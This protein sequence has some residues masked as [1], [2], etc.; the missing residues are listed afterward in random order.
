MSQSIRLTEVDEVVAAVV[1][2]TEP[3]VRI[4]IFPEGVQTVNVA[5]VE[6][7]NGIKAYVTESTS[8]SKT[9]LYGLTCELVE[10]HI[11]ISTY[12]K[13]HPVMGLL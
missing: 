1:P 6:V 5:V 8:E 11:T 10:R 4:D 9:W 2:S 13:M 7:E 3:V 12:G